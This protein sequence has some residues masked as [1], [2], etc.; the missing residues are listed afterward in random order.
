M[1]V[2][3]KADHVGNH[4]GAYTDQD[5]MSRQFTYVDHDKKTTISINQ[6]NTD[7]ELF[8]KQYRAELIKRIASISASLCHEWFVE[9]TVVNQ[10]KSILEWNMDMLL[11]NGVPLSTLRDICTVME[12]RA[13]S[14][15][16]L[17]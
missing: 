4:G 7:Y 17:I 6:D 14:H 13:E 9:F 1:A 3:R 10:E 8:F 12:N 15:T 5:G 2:D 16:K 11:D